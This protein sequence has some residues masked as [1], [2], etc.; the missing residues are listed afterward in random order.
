MC[1]SIISRKEA[2]TLF[3]TLTEYSGSQHTINFRQNSCRTRV[4]T[5]T[6]Q[7]ILWKTMKH[8]LCHYCSS[9]DKVLVL[10]SAILKKQGMAC[11]SDQQF[12]RIICHQV[13]KIFPL[14]WNGWHK[15]QVTLVCC[16]SF[17]L[18]IKMQEYLINYRAF[19][20]MFLKVTCPLNMDASIVF[21]GLSHSSGSCLCIYC[22]AMNRTW[23]SYLQSDLHSRAKIGLHWREM[24]E[25]SHTSWI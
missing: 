5:W 7:I 14:F 21:H 1:N 19:R 25:I 4:Q 6:L 9:T 15:V 2:W 17:R 24:A 12:Q 11:Y 10:L 18:I 16:W 22:P 23:N 13:E 20:P 3:S 8:T